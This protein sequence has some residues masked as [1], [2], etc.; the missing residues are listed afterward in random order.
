MFAATGEIQPEGIGVLH[1][2][3]I[4][5]AL[6]ASRTEAPDTR[7]RLKNSHSS[8]CRPKGNDSRQWMNL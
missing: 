2:L 7:P 8:N 4:F 3:N 5:E 6:I 1:N